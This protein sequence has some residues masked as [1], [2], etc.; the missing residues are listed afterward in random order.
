MNSTYYLR[1]YIKDLYQKK[2]YSPELIFIKREDIYNKVKKAYVQQTDGKGKI[3]RFVEVDVS[4]IPKEH[5]IHV[6]EHEWDLPST[7]QIGDEIIRIFIQDFAVAEGEKIRVRVSRGTQQ[8]KERV[9]ST[10]TENV[11]VAA[12]IDGGY[13]PIVKNGITRFDQDAYGEYVEIM[14]KMEEKKKKVEE[15]KDSI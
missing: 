14:R 10:S 13:S 8:I 5:L 11:S 1:S 6:N 2:D 7:Y 4:E 15:F 9:K 3:E 12:A